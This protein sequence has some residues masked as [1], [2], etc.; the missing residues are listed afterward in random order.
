[1]NIPLLADKTGEISKAYGVYKED[2]GK[3][4]SQP[5]QVH[6]VP[7]QTANLIIC[8]ILVVVSS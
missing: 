7:D 4:H 5:N 1:M 2:E 3:Q 6:S 8:A